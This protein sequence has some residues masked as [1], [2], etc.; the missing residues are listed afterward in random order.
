MFLC[1][2]LTDAGIQGLERIPTLEELDLS[3]SAVTSVSHLSACQSLKRL[4]LTGYSN[5]SDPGIQGLE[6]IPTL[7][8]LDLMRCTGIT[9]VSHLRA[10]KALKRLELFGCEQLAEE[11]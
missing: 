3:Y 7:E 2:H 4:V 1:H 10:R 5:F 11:C 9:S 6:L 8:E